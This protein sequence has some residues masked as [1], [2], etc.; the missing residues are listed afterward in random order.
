LVIPLFG[1]DFVIVDMCEAIRAV[2]EAAIDITTATRYRRSVVRLH[3]RTKYVRLR[4]CSVIIPPFQT[5]SIG[6][7]RHGV[8]L[9]ERNLVGSPAAAN[10]EA[11]PTATADEYTRRLVLCQGEVRPESLTLAARAVCVYYSPQGRER[12]LPYAF[13]D[14]EGRVTQTGESVCRQWGDPCG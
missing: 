2:A 4:D 11:T 14:L 9:A 1:H 5:T 6:K 10:R 12:Q 8:V 3:L 13:A 7:L